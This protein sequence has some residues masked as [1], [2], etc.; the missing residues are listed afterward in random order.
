[1]M[2]PA[3]WAELAL[4]TLAS[5]AAVAA[6]PLVAG[7]W[8]WSWD[9]LNHH[10]YLG[11]ISESPRWHLD[12]MAASVQGWQYPYLYW[13]VYQLAQWRI[14]GPT[15]GALWSALLAALVVPPVWLMSLRLLQGPAAQPEAHSANARVHLWP[16]WAQA[17]FERCCATALALSS[18]VVLSAMGTTS[19]DPLAAVPLLWAIALMLQ[20]LPSNR[21]AALAA[22][23]W[24]VAVAFKPTAVLAAPLLLVWW[25]A[26]GGTQALMRRGAVMAMGGT[27]GFALAYLPWGWQLWQQT[28]N[29][30]YPFLPGW[31]GP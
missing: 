14:S 13:P 20:P 17:L 21:R 5:M 27:L 15:A 6:V 8:G 9:A 11:L 31:F 4:V 28:G 12:V 18:V 10:V 26:P 30:V 25:W 19:N 7:E 2:K 29:P 22:A 3:L 24:A 16:S 1:M 23:L